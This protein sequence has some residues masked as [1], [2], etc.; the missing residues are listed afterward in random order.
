MKSRIGE[1]LLAHGCARTWQHSQAVALEARD[2]ALAYGVDE[3][4]ALQAAWLHDISAVIP[5]GEWLEAARRFGLEI[6]AEEAA[7][8]MILH[9]KL[10]AAL[11]RQEF[12]VEDAA[13]L[14]AIGCHTTLKAGYAP[15]DLVLFV[16]DKLAWDQAGEAP[17]APALRAGLERGLEQGAL[18]Y[19]DHLWQR[20]A[21]LGCVH[22][23]MIAAR[24]ELIAFEHGSNG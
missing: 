8:P 15:L 4:S 22:P 11:A 2:L 16:A 1:Y 20:R 14:S 12:G 18:A 3:G 23:W 7:F 24:E 21:E 6:L 19:L 5:N 9:Q 17:Y 10:S 13:I